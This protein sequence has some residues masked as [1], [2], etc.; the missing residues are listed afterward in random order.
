MGLSI[1]LATFAPQLH[2]RPHVSSTIFAVEAPC[3]RADSIQQHTALRQYRVM[4]AIQVQDVG[5]KERFY[6]DFQQ[7]VAG[8]S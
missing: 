1:S 3:A 7:G 5:L 4:A 2:S 8:E 6:R